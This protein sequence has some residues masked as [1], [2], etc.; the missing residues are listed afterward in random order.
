MSL[1]E[2]A[3]PEEEFLRVSTLLLKKGANLREVYPTR[4]IRI[5]GDKGASVM[6]VF[7][8]ND[9]FSDP[10][11]LLA[12]LKK[13]FGNGTAVV[14]LNL[15]DRADETLRNMSSTQVPVDSHRD[16]PVQGASIPSK[17]SA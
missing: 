16:S 7:L 3:N 2:Q 6:V 8:G 11:V 9:A 5:L 17:S 12:R 15:I 13:M 4:L 1:L 10:V 14:L